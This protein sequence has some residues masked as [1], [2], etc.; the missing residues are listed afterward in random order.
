M[1]FGLA[2]RLYLLV[3]LF[4][5]GCAAL[6]VPLIWLHNDRTRA[7]SEANLKSLTELAT[8]VLETHRKM[9]AAGQMSEDEAKKRALSEIADMRYAG[10]NYFYVMTPQGVMV[11]NPA[12]PKLVGQ[13]R[14]DVK[15]SR[16][17]F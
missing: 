16:G 5:V 4:A 15:D 9:A 2:A 13:S 10:V 8:S 12:Q 17:R 7:R 11:M 3:A 1:K 14:M 6:A